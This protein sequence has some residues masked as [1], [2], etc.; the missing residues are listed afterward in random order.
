M[1]VGGAAVGAGVYY[2]EVWDDGFAYVLTI[3]GGVS[4]LGGGLTML[5]K[6]EAERIADAHDVTTTSSP[7]PEQE[8][9]L[10]RDW[11]KAALQTR[12]ARHLGGAMSLGLTAI[13]AGTA[14]YVVAA[15]PVEDETEHWLI[16]TLIIGGAATAA[17]GLVAFMVEMP[18]ETAYRQ[19][20][21]TRG[22]RPPASFTPNFRVGAAPLPRGGGIVSIST[23]F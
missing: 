9:A 12:A 21:A 13:A 1:I 3:A 7:T 18:T 14:I 19:F 8:A 20:K 4:I 5:I 15:E 6:S 17:A 2:Q 16:P 22:A 11:E 23:V 10:E